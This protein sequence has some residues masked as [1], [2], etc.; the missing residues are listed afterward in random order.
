MV[1]CNFQVI[2]GDVGCDKQASEAADAGTTATHHVI[3]MPSSST[4]KIYYQKLE[5][6]I[7]RYHFDT[8]FDGVPFLNRAFELVLVLLGP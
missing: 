1:D 5:W 2:S 4:T 8:L 7:R 3:A 6:S